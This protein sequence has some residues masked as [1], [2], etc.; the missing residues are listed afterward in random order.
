MEDIIDKVLKAEKDAE[1][2]LNEAR[3]RAQELKR[4]ME[5]EEASLIDDAHVQ[6]AKSVEEAFALAEENAERNK[7]QAS[8]DEHRRSEEFL[9]LN[10][11]RLEGVLDKLIALIIE[12]EHK[13]N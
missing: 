6:G 13:K 4:R 9:Q 5:E 7:A 1:V 8:E 10:R 2:V 11:K 12:P 3:A